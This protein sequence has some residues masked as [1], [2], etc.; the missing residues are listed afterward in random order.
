MNNIK[1]SKTFRY[2]YKHI[3]EEV[4][5]EICQRNLNYSIEYKIKNI[6]I[7]YAIYEKFEEYRK[8]TA[9][10]MAGNRLDRHKLASCMCGTILELR[11]IVPYNGATPVK[12]ANEFVA[13]SISLAILKHYMIDDLIESSIKSGKLTSEEE[14]ICHNYLA[15]NFYINFPSAKEN[16]R[17]LCEYNVIITNA[18]LFNNKECTYKSGKCLQY[19]V[20]AYSL[21]FY[22]LELYNRD[23]L[24]N[25]FEE[26]V[27]AVSHHKLENIN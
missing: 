11:P 20:W 21:L 3:I 6:P 8:I 17:D 25:K 23:I 4:F 14:K 18:L 22:H 27:D 24:N 16:I 5:S 26:F 15:S 1:P 10:N 12:K 19:D 2:L 7:H 9:A 13:L